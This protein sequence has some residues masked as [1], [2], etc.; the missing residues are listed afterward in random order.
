MTLYEVLES[1]GKYN[2]YDIATV[3]GTVI[4][5]GINFQYMKMAIEYQEDAIEI[6]IESISEKNVKTI[7]L[8]NNTI[9]LC[10]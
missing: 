7:D 9:Y 10:D 1:I 5:K 4:I 3:N 6:L 2:K 8:L